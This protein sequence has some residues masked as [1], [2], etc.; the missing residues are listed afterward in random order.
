MIIQGVSARQEF[1]IPFEDDHLAKK[2]QLCEGHNLFGKYIVPGDCVIL[3]DWLMEL[4]HINM[5]LL[6][7]IVNILVII[8]VKQ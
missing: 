6:I 4:G 1:N 8:I 7:Y 5:D 2:L 3:G